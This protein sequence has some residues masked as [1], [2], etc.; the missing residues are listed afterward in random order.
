MKCGAKNNSQSETLKGF[1]DSINR[2]I[3]PFQ[4]LGKFVFISLHFVQSYSHWT[5]RVAKKEICRT[6]NEK[7]ILNDDKM[8]WV[9]S[10]GE[11]VVFI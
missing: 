3:K 11:L 4:G 8:F 1:N 9:L 10:K 2:I 5:L 6:P 7:R